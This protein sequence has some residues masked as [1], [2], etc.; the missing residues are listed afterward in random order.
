MTPC[1]L[2]RGID[3]G[4]IFG[5]KLTKICQNCLKNNEKHFLTATIEIILLQIINQFWEDALP[6]EHR[7]YH[8]LARDDG[9]AHAIGTGH[10]GRVAAVKFSP[11]MQSI[12]SVGS[13]GAIFIWNRN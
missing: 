8:N 6:T 12:V 9:I 1:N 4:F 10:S 7:A 5:D 2:S 13:E 11:D 3:L